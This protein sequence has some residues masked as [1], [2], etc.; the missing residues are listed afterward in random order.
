MAPEPERA[1]LIASRT[2]KRKKEK[3]KGG[4]LLCQVLRHQAQIGRG[5]RSGTRNQ[6]TFRL[7]QPKQRQES[8]APH[9]QGRRRARVGPSPA[10]FMKKPGEAG[11]GRAYFFGKPGRAR[12]RTGLQI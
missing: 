1:L 12:A 8:D 10:Y 3:G 9:Q 6:G 2:S 4:R 5:K 7:A 11:P